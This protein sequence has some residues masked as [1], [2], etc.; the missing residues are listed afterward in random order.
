MKIF[1]ATWLFESN[2]GLSLTKAKAK[3]RLLSYYHLSEKKQNLPVYILTGK[4]KKE[5]KAK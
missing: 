2:Q 3:S 1:F 4:N 5:K